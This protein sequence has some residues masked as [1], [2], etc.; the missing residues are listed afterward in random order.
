M[1][2]LNSKRIATDG[3][4]GWLSNL[5]LTVA[6]ALFIVLLVFDLVERFG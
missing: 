5:L 6:S 1:L 4:S 3:R 2:L